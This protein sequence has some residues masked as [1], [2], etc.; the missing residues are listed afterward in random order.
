MLSDLSHFVLA[1]A[2][3][4][5]AS[6]LHVYFSALPFSPHHTALFK[7]YSH[8]ASDYISV[9]Q[10]V[11]RQWPKALDIFLGHS[12]IVNSV[13]FSPDVSRLA[14]GS[15]DHSV[16][17]WDATST[18]ALASLVGHS[19]GVYCVAF[20]P[21]DCSWCQALLTTLYDYGRLIRAG[22]LNQS[23]VILTLFFQLHFPPT[24]YGWPRGLVIIVCD[25]G[26]P[27]RARVLH[28]SSM[29]VG[30]LGPGPLHFHRTDCGS[31]RTIITLPVFS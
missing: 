24:A 2:E 11:G 29:V 13:V 12:D 6:A 27:D 18:E 3:V 30:W 4:I 25:C 28:R 8:E 5:K 26:M 7:A 21:V 9:L 22:S 16:R 14:S 20:S 19:G 23:L 31:P 1:H 10:G 17:L 15:D